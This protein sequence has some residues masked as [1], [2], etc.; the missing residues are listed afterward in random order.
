MTEKKVKPTLISTGKVKHPCKCTVISKKDPPKTTSHTRE[1]FSDG[2]TRW[3][4]SKCGQV[5]FS[6]GYE[7][8]KLE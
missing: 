8:E 3:V 2:W 1:V 4:C 6:K 7:E 5:K